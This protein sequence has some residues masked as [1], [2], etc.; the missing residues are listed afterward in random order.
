AP[1]RR[2]RRDV[3]AELET[4]VLKAMAKDPAERYATA[5]DLADDLRRFLDDQPI[6]ARRPTLRQVVGKWMRRHRAL[7]NTAAVLAAVG[8]LGLTVA[9]WRTERALAQARAGR[10]EAH[11]AVDRMYSYAAENLLGMNPAHVE[12]QRQFLEEALAFYE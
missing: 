3:P 12:K 2:R 1:P 7:V 11:R 10:A 6:R 4:I 9:V 5:Q 8:F